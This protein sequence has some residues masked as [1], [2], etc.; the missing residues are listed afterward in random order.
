MFCTVVGM[1]ITF[2]TWT[3]NIVFYIEI[4]LLKQIVSLNMVLQSD[5]VKAVGRMQVVGYVV[6]WQ[7]VFILQPLNFFVTS[8]N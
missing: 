7:K 1:L 8:V 4:L 6:R 2:Q 5:I 3:F